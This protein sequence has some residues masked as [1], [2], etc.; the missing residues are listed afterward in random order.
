MVSGA[1]AEL[2][3]Q[4]APGLRVGLSAAFAFIATLLLA[5]I[6]LTACGGDDEPPAIDDV[7]APNNEI[8]N[9]AA[10]AFAPVAIPP[11]TAI[12]SGIN[13]IDLPEDVEP[14]AFSFTQVEL[15]DGDRDPRSMAM[16]VADTFDRRTRG[17]MFRD[18]LPSNTGM[19]FAFPAPTNGPFWN[20]D[21]PFDLDLAV[22]SAEG[23]IQEIL[24]LVALNTELVTPLTEYS[25]AV[26]MPLGWFDLNAYSVGDRFVIPEGVVGLTE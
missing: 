25:F 1:S 12:P 21:V 17:L 19:L 7:P 4:R 3:Q 20:K 15:I 16:L 18:G 9:Q 14:V 11:A 22:L 10:L 24:I 26:E 8:L 23:E 6:P 2:G 5:A 13:E